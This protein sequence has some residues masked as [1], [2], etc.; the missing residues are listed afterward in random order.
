M[1]RKGQVAWREQLERTL[2]NVDDLTEKDLGT[3]S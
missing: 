3:R 1:T 2:S